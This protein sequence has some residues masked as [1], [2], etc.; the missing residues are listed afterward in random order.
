MK[1]L[2]GSKKVNTP[3]QRPDNIT[4]GSLDTF[5]GCRCGDAGAGFSVNSGK[6]D[7]SFAITGKR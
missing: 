1:Q 7:N 5:Q 2:S 4:A 6:P 3:P